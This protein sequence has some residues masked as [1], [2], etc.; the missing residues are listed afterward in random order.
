MKDK[1]RQ[2]LVAF[3]LLFVLVMSGCTT[4][5][6]SENPTDVPIQNDIIETVDEP[7]LSE[8]VKE[9]SAPQKK[10]EAKSS[11]FDLSV[12][13]E[14]SGKPYVAVND[15][16]PFFTEGD[17]TTAAF[18]TYS[19]LDSL[20]RC[21]EAYANVCKDTMPTQPRGNI[22]PVKPSGWH[23]VRYE[24]VDGL[25]LY[26]RCHLIGFQLTGENAN[27]ENLITG[28]RYLNIQGML[29][30]ENMVAAYVKETGNHVLYRVTPIFEGNNLLAS[31]VLMEGWSVEDE[32]DGI[33][34]NVY[35][36]NV[37]PDIIIDYSDGSNKAADGSAP[38]GSAAAVTQQK[39]ETTQSNTSAKTNS[40]I[41]N[42]NTGKLHYSWCSSVDQMKDTNKKYLNCTREQA[43]SQGYDPCKRCNP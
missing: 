8:P 40:Y 31:G 23:S 24:N 5:P 15:N 30:F 6:T 20:G 22:G 11:S 28:T 34:Y 36:Y 38:Y 27:E 12:V 37:Q 43:L 18:E 21:G 4:T 9:P 35:C 10:P 19:S 7:I 33:C 14:Y 26:N 41:A 32:G 3:L 1:I 13:P 29:P 42:K 39:K 2:S 16:I 25:Y 17:M